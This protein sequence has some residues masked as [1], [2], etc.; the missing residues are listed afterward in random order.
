MRFRFTIPLLGSLLAT[1]VVAVGAGSPVQAANYS[2]TV[3]SPVPVH[4]LSL[5][6]I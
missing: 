6:H 1:A 3:D 4:I 2:L 5:I